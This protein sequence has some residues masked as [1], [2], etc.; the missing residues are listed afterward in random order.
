LSVLIVAF[1]GV[2]LIVGLVVVVVVLNAGV[3]WSEL[4]VVFS[5]S[6]TYNSGSRVFLSDSCG[7]VVTVSFSRGPLKTADVVVGVVVVVVYLTNPEK[8]A[9]FSSSFSSPG[10]RC[11]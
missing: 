1:N 5:V 2:M 7:A 8:S 9:W 4:L 6:M 11:P 10:H 3:V